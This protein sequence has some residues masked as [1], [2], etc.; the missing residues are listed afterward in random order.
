[1]GE[2]AT[3]HGGGGAEPHGGGGAASHDHCVRKRGLE[4]YKRE[5][6]CG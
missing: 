6:Q 4:L 5:V 1:M 3:P 2:G